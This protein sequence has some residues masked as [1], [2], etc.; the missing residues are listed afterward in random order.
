[1]S[2]GHLA[3]LQGL[4]RHF[5]SLKSRYG[6]TMNLQCHAKGKGADWPHYP[7]KPLHVPAAT[8]LN[9]QQRNQTP[10]TCSSART[11]RQ[12]SNDLFPA[13]AAKSSTKKEE[14]KLKVVGSNR[15]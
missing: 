7:H 11:E 4:S 14:G 8:L 3:D 6:A 1:M 12:P 5:T 13:V 15:Q 10:R 9:T 2:F